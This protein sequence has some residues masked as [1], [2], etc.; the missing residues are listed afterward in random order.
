MLIKTT[1][2][3]NLKFDSTMKVKIEDNLFDSERPFAKRIT[4]YSDNTR[5]IER[6]KVITK[7]SEL[8]DVVGIN[9]FETFE[10]YV[11]FLHDCL[12]ILKENQADK[13]K[14]ELEEYE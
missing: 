6:Y 2:Y 13:Y 12:V 14:E 8:E 1:E 7:P 5:L 9:W 10:E 11:T 4:E 3:V